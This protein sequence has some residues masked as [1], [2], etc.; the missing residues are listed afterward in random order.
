MR[1]KWSLASQGCCEASFTECFGLPQLSNKS[2]H[3]PTSKQINMS[4][5]VN[6]IHVK[7]HLREPE[8]DDSRRK[9]K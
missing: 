2:Q 1:K 9:V 7:V 8:E 4:A 5:Q 6:S 3:K